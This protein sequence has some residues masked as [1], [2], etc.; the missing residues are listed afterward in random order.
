MFRSSTAVAFFA[1]VVALAQMATNN[2]VN[3]TVSQNVNQQTYAAAI[4]KSSLPKKDEAIVIDAVDG[5]SND[6]YIDGL[7]K[8]TSVSNIRYISK[9]SGSRVCIYLAN[10]TLVNE[11]K[12][13]EI[14]IKEYVLR[15]KPLINNNK[16]IVISNV[17]PIIPDDIII[18]ALKS[19]GIVIVSRISELR[20]SLAK[21]GRT[22]IQSFRR[23]F[24]IK[25]DDEKLIP[26]T[27]Q[28]N[29]D[30]TS[31]WTFLS[32]DSTA[33]FVCK[34]AGHV[35]KLCPS[36]SLTAS[37]PS[38][39]QNEISS[40][41]SEQNKDTQ[42]QSQ[43]MITKNIKKR[44]LSITSE[45]SSNTIQP[46]NINIQPSS[47]ENE[48]NPQ[49][50]KSNKDNHEKFLKPTKQKKKRK[51]KTDQ[52]SS[53]EDNQEYIRNALT[54]ATAV[55]QNIDITLSVDQFAEFLKRKLNR[56]NIQEELK[57]YVQSSV[58]MLNIIEKV[59]PTITNSSM[60]TRLTKLKKLIEQIELQELTDIS[61]ME[62][63][64]TDSEVETQ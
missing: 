25:E 32:A 55:F 12:N 8:L 1:T 39:E 58:D 20:A 11:L 40:Q 52:E 18:S 3:Y 34:Q 23:Q 29:Y 64:T 59:Y 31:Y 15:I 6:D 47:T 22:H 26:D 2:D 17:H 50:N 63:L 44:P 48:T 9:I 19:K 53:T 54:P 5:L 42:F 14:Q 46:N 61:E 10:K 28:L 21:P 43:V 60:K 51:L 13:K 27:L 49:E 45:S 37:L 4:A 62:I 30:N 56:Q 33:C 36:N 57:S 7:E 38:Q 41:L 16:R 35:A 24:Y